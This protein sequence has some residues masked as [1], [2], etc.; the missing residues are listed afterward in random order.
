MSVIRTISVPIVCTKFTRDTLVF[1][2]PTCVHGRKGFQFAAPV[3]CFILS[4]LRD[5]QT[6]DIYETRP[7][8]VNSSIQRSRSN[9]VLLAKYRLEYNEKYSFFRSFFPFDLFE[10]NEQNLS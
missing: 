4:I 5:A 7:G 3:W 10:T 8:V 9:I 1:F 2:H 6:C